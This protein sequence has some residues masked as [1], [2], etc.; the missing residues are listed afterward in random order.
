MKGSRTQKII[1][2]CS[3]ALVILLV[4][5]FAAMYGVIHR[6]KN[7]PPAE[8]QAVLNQKFGFPV[9]FSEV[10]THWKGLS[11]GLSF[12]NVVVKDTPEP[13]PFLSANSLELR[14]SFLNLMLKPDLDFDRV[15]VQGLRLILGWQADQPLTLLG[16]QKEALSSSID[17]QNVL[18]ILAEK[19]L[20]IQEAEI[21][22]V[23]SG[24]IIAQE[25]DGI[26]KSNKNEMNFKGKQRLRMQGEKK[27]DTKKANSEEDKDR[28]YLPP[29]RLIFNL[30]KV[31]QEAHLETELLNTK[32]E[33]DLKQLEDQ[34][35]HCLG[36]AKNISIQ[37]IHENIHLQEGAP[38][39]LRWLLNALE[40][41]QIRELQFKILGSWKNLNL[42]GDV[43]YRD[44]TFR[45]LPDW[46]KF[47]HAHGRVHFNQ[48]KVEIE[49]TE[50]DIEGAY[51]PEVHATVG[52]LNEK[53]PLEVKIEG[54]AFGTL[55]EGLQFLQHSPLKEKIGDDIATLHPKGLM[56]LN[57]KLS[58]PLAKK[59]ENSEKAPVTAQGK[60]S[61]KEADLLLSLL[62]LPI[63]HV[64][65]V[66]EFTEKSVTAQNV[67]TEILGQPFVAEVNSEKV[68]V[69]GP[70]K[71]E[72][73]QERFK[74]PALHHLSG[75]SIFKI[76]YAHAD[77]L[78]HIDSHLK[79]VSLDLPKPLG[80]EKDSE[81]LFQVTIYPE[82][83][84][85]QKF[86]LRV[87]DLFDSKWVFQEKAAH[88]Q[89]TPSHHSG[90]TLKR[91][92]VIFGGN[93]EW[94]KQDVLYL[95][96]SL[97]ELNVNTWWDFIDN[98]SGWE[99]SPVRV[100]VFSDNL[101]VFGMTFPKTWID[102]M[103]QWSLSGPTIE[104]FLILPQ[105]DKQPSKQQETEPDKKELNLQLNYLKLSSEDLQAEASFSSFLK[106]KMPVI[107][108]CKQISLD[109]RFFGQ[110]AFKLI[111]R[112][113]GFDIIDMISRSENY[114][115]K[116]K[117]K[118]FIE[119]QRAQTQLSGDIVSNNFGQAFSDWGLT[120]S[121]KE[122]KGRIEFD[123][124]WPKAP[125]QFA[126]A[127]LE[128]NLYLAIKSGRIL[129]VDPGLGKILGLLSIENLHRRLMLDFSDLYKS[130][131]AFNVLDGKLYFQEGFVY[132]E[133]LNMD[134]SVATI[135]L[136]GK[137][138][139]KNKELN[140]RMSVAPKVGGGL[141]LAAGLAGGPAAF[142]GVWI[143]GKVVGPKFGTL[144]Q[145][146][147]Q[148]T[149]TWDAPILNGMASGK[150]KRNGR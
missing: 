139:L 65:G 140:L 47:E 105:Q 80:K 110:L 17:Y 95:N 131:F 99:G 109:N 148:V 61:V 42:E 77:R 71:I 137:A 122:G 134:S 69:T 44:V 116:G 145:Q 97:P 98:Q 25:L 16:L 123:L 52:P 126:L 27:P 13:V 19:E 138:N 34:Q 85:E 74:F 14:S 43:A 92:H 149:G 5:C 53:A 68:S 107:F 70:I 121:V 115:L 89:N 54:K 113:H 37:P 21:L 136:Y 41:G 124:Q 102:K 2:L 51:I 31:T 132:T 18:N 127:D 79:G 144:G 78:W 55:E 135:G 39:W 81:K 48:E 120:S 24:T 130:G 101:T 141:P 33:C 73:L 12:K 129:G 125:F 86:A 87:Q 1:L 111:P 142:F 35:L 114:Y 104:G 112:D 66:F 49:M 62:D 106:E 20:K 76:A 3:A 8:I 100:H 103:D 84:D 22:W 32:L 83:N 30:N 67:Q 7:I 94:L 58:I 146:Y 75:E 40:K 91:G 93:A 11:L 147:Y 63:K 128:G 38:D 45:F 9:E 57:L 50:G 29:S 96:G 46:P 26:L 118:W 28:F 117:G 4:L 108:N 10:K 6:V 143:F 133:G 150:S 90:Y 119:D 72:Y 60:V 88:S 23:G 15:T 59:T 36:K 56:D 82:E 64:N